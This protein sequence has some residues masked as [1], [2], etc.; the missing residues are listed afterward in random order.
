MQKR[1][2]LWAFDLP[3]QLNRMGRRSASVARASSRENGTLL[4]MFP[5]I[6]FS[7][8]ARR[9]RSS[10]EMLRPGGAVDFVA[11]TGWTIKTAA[12]EFFPTGGRHAAFAHDEGGKGQLDRL[13]PIMRHDDGVRG[14][15]IVPGWLSLIRRMVP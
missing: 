2:L 8:S 6:V 11:W 1:A 3:F 14:R 9:R 13:R 10:S 5:S 4:L 7:V 12:D 15:A